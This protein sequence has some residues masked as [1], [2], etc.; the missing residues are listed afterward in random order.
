MHT[1]ILHLDFF[2]S[3]ILASYAVGWSLI[4]L[5]ARQDGV[6]DLCHFVRRFI[7]APILTVGIALVCIIVYCFV[8]YM[9]LPHFQAILAGLAGAA[10]GV[11][12]FVLLGNYVVVPA[13][14]K[15]YGIVQPFT[16]KICV[17]LYRKK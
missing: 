2:L 10:L 13:V 7:F 4:A 17:V 15:S 8:R 6:V 1:I 11:L 14:K 12:F 9:F 5:K 16:S 3:Y